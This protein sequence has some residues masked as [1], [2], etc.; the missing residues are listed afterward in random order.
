MSKRRWMYIIFALGVACVLVPILLNGLVPELVPSWILTLT[1]PLGGGLAGSA[2]GNLKH[3]K[4]LA[5]DPA[6]QKRQK[7]LHDERNTAIRSKA[8]GIA[9]DICMTA[10]ILVIM[11]AHAMELIPLW[12]LGLL[13]GIYI[14]KYIL[15]EL[16]YRWLQRKM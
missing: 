1:S 6:Y 5:Q 4:R 7:E 9:G 13:G 10:M 15:W 11:V 8:G 12:L 14:F 2:V 3:Q 16:L